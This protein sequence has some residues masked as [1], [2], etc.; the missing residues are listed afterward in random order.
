MG[1]C[2]Y[3][4]MTGSCCGRRSWARRTGSSPSSPGPAGGSAPW[5]RASAGPSP[6]FG[7]RLEPFTHVDL[8][9]HP[10]R[11]LDVITQAEVIRP[12][13]EPLTGDYPRYTAGRGDAGDGR[14]VHPGG[15]GAVA[16]P[17]AAAHRRA[18]RP[19]RRRARPAPGARRLPAALARGGRIRARPA[20]VRPLRRAG[21]AREP[22]ACAGASPSRPGGMVCASCRPPGAASPA[23]TDGGP[24][25]RPAPRRL[26]SRRS[27]ASAGTG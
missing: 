17:A 24:D 5:P 22:A 20:G 16:A 21:T 14:A 23:G 25:A 13:G 2:S 7:A 19:R 12:Y 15:E 6:R 26:G 27:A 9:L 1:G 3:T 18:A 4:G 8:M 10:G 11:S